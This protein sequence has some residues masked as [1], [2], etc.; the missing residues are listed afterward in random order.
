[1]LTLKVRGSSRGFLI[2]IMAAVLFALTFCLVSFGRAQEKA[3][4]EK[5]VEKALPPQTE[6]ASG[7]QMYMDYCASCHGKEGR[8]DGPTAAEFKV[9]PPDLTLLAKKNNGKFPWEHVMGVLRFGVKVPAHGTTDMPIWGPVFSSIEPSPSK[10][11]QRMTN[12]TNYV[13]TLQGT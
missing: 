2:G 4:Q 13:K 10:L 6:R 12:L 1:M 5:T 9:P 11:E 8:G 7:K 3:P